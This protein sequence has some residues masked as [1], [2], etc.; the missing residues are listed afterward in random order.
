MRFIQ[1]LCAVLFP[2][3]LS[4]G[5]NASDGRGL[6]IAAEADN[7]DIGFGDTISTMTMTLYDQYGN[8][9]SRKIRNKTLEGTDQGDLSLGY[10]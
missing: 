1:I 2:F 5:L 10:F 7:R 8:T 9:T 4:T 6:E 3:I